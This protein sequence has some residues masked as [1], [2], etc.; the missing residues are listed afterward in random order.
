IQQSINR[1]FGN[2]KSKYKDMAREALKKSRFDDFT[3][4]GD[5]YESTLEDEKSIEKVVKFRSYIVNH[6]DYI[7]DW[8]KRVDDP[9]KESRGIR[10]MEF[11]QRLVSFCMKMRGI[12]GS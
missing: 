5:T 1:T 2:K 7:S 9:P 8:R 4:A 6:W 3:L 10:A 12:E 11:H